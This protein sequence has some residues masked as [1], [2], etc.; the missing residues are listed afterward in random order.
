MKF[1][2]YTGGVASLDGIGDPQITPLGRGTCDGED[3]GFRPEIAGIIVTEC[4]VE[5][6][7]RLEAGQRP[8]GRKINGINVI[9]VIGDFLN[10]VTEFLRGGHFFCAQD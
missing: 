4:Q 2:F 5:E 9:A 10:P 7:A 6:L 1:I 3:T 8:L